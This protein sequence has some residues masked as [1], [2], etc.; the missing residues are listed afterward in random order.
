[1]VEQPRASFFEIS[2]ER[3]EAKMKGKIGAAGKSETGSKTVQL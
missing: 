1:M 2:R 3:V